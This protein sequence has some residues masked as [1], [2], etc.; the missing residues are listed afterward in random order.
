MELYILR[1]GLAEAAPNPPS[2]GDSRRRLTK[3]GANKMRRAAKGMKALEL[4]F[5]LILSS[6]YLRARETAEIVADAMAAVKNVEFSNALT[7]DSDPRVLIEDLTRK[8]RAKKQVLVVGH[9]PYLSRLI[10][11]LISGD[12]RVTIDFKK[13]ALCKLSALNL[14]Y[15]QCAALEWLMTSKQLR[16]V[17]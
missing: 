13:G 4:S 12:T 8:H 2:S 15:G 11:L 9:E 17:E 10:S 3:E 1:H 5:D 16:Q 6:P 7:P 14:G